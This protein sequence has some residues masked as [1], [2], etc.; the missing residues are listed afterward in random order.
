MCLWTGHWDQGTLCPAWLRPGLCS[1]YWM[2]KY[3][4]KDMRD[5][6]GARGVLNP[7]QTAQL[8]CMGEGKKED[9]QSYQRGIA[10]TGW[11][12]KPSS[13]PSWAW[14][15][16]GRSYF[17]ASSEATGA[18]VANGTNWHGLCPG[19]VP[20]NLS[21]S[22]SFPFCKLVC[23]D[24][25]GDFGNHMLKMAEPQDGRSLGPCTTT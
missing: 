25:Q 3:G 19:L 10:E 5:H 20:K 9:L 16:I 8:L 1:Y 18:Q 11:L 14:T 24:M 13:S 12:L 7:T 21:P 22:C 4:N 17:P 23:I 2:L 6:P 15:G